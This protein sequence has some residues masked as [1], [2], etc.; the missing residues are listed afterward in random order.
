MEFTHN[1]M[2]MA[3]LNCKTLEFF[4]VDFAIWAMEITVHWAEM[5]HTTNRGP[6]F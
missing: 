6:A 1:A 3:V 5:H 2:Q 4:T